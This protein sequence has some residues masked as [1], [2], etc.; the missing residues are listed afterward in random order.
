MVRGWL[1]ECAELGFDVTGA[2]IY[3]DISYG[4]SRAGGYLIRVPGGVDVIADIGYAGRIDNR[5]VVG[6]VAVQ[7]AIYA[8]LHSCLLRRLERIGP[9]N[10]PAWSRISPK[11]FRWTV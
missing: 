8:A 6:S 2:T 1:G 11:S 7:V 9:R 5:S 3:C 4:C 10:Q